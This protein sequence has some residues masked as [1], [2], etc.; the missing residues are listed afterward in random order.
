MSGSSVLYTD[1]QAALS[2]G[3]QQTG[4]RKTRDLA[5]HYASIVDH[6]RNRRLKLVYCPT[7]DITAD[8]LTKGLCGYK[9]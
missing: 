5:N 3:E 4:S 7:D 9:F 1:N 2:I 6:I 8:V